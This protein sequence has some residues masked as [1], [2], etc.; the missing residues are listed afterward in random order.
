MTVTHIYASISQPTHT[1]SELAL[2]H[3]QFRTSGSRKCIIRTFVYVTSMLNARLGMRLS[4]LAIVFTWICIETSSDWLARSFE[5]APFSATTS[6]S[7]VW[8]DNGIHNHYTISGTAIIIVVPCMSCVCVY[9]SMCEW[10]CGSHQKPGRQDMLSY[11]F[12][13]Q[14]NYSITHSSLFPS[15][16]LLTIFARF[17]RVGFLFYVQTEVNKYLECQQLCE[18]VI[19]IIITSNGN[20]YG[21]YGLSMST[22][23]LK[24]HWISKHSTQCLTNM[25]SFHWNLIFQWSFR[26]I[27]IL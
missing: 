10:V 25:N 21:R 4:N 24:L 2:T 27:S 16:S 22:K 1:H 11:V 5:A 20:D 14:K 9:Y 7:F 13:S 8:Y 12:S 15:T 3:S 17:S 23:V 6:I 19:I 26:S 18:T